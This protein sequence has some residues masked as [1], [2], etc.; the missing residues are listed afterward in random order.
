[1]KKVLT[2]RP[3]YGHKRK[4]H[5]VRQRENRGDYEALP[6]MTG[7]R[8]PYSYESKEFSDLISPLYRFLWSC[9][10][11]PWDDVWSE[12]C[13]QLSN[14]T[15]DAHL[16]DHARQIV[17]I[18]T[19]LDNDGNVFVCPRFGIGPREPY[20][21]YVDPRT[22]ILCGNPERRSP[23]KSDV[24]IIWKD[25]LSYTE[26]DGVL[27]PRETY[28]RRT[29][30]QSAAS[31]HPDYPRKILADGRECFKAN[32]IWYWAV[33]KDMERSAWA[34]D[35][36]TFAVTDIVTGKEV[37]AGRYRAGKR[38]MSKTDLRRHGLKND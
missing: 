29:W 35:Y 32:G 38:Q 8:R 7:M 10:G 23:W 25:G 4:Y 15:V 16:K 19:F 9:L 26:E 12:I 6:M 17:E 30:K 3:R 24:E 36:K 5:E 2:E 22:G 31:K 34:A 27:Q 13:S 33:F 11:R 18:D 14:N 28:G 37:K 21:L 1:M 20:G